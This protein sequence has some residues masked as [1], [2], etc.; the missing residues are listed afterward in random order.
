MDNN[1]WTDAIDQAIKQLE[2]A[3]MR[4][5]FRQNPGSVFR[6]LAFDFHVL[7][8][9]YAPPKPVAPSSSSSIINCPLCGH[10]VEVNLTKP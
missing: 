4:S 3:K 2:L 6:M 1:A 5:E 10:P 7:A 9:A 8:K